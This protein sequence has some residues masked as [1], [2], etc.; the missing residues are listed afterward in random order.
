MTRLVIPNQRAASAAPA[1]S[2]REG[3]AP[4][5]AFPY[6][7]SL[8]AERHAAL[9]ALLNIARR[10]LLAL[11]VMGLT[12]IGSVGAAAQTRGPVSAG[13]PADTNSWAASS[14]GLLE[15]RP[16]AGAFIPTGAERSV[17]KDA[18]LA[19]AQL[20][21]RPIPQFAVTGTF[22]WTPNNNQ[23]TPGAPTLDVYQY[24][25]G[26][27]ARGAGWLEGDGWDFT[28]FVGV[29]GGG[30]TYSYRDLGLA[31]TTDVDGYGSVG[32]DIGYGRF[33]LRVEGRDYLSQ[34][35]PLSGVGT[36]TNR[37][38]VALAVGLRIRL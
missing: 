4:R 1:V 14:D 28:P 5:F 11:L 33:G 17:L 13:Q 21:V 32:A 22:G 34:F 38:D 24:D 7:R 19:G 3:A 2:S 15:I 27:E 26:V 6:G 36:T 16:F 25:L 18:V 12:V 30:R 10:V 8:S 23:L 29:G 31:S 20:S 35:H 9:V 37:N